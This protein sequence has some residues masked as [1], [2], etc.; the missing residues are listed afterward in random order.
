MARRKRRPGEVVCHCGRYGFP[1]RFMGGYCDGGAW[2][3]E[4]F[5]RELWGECKDC[6]LR[7]TDDATGEIRC[8]VLDGTEE[9]RECPSLMEYVRFEGVKLYGMNRLPDK[10]MGWRR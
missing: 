2:I 5:T 4:F 7:V 10:R 8:Q 6:P 1:H 9:N 3:D